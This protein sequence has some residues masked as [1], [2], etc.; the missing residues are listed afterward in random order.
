MKA[1]HLLLIAVLV[2]SGCG[3][4]SKNE[5]SHHKVPVVGDDSSEKEPQE[6]SEWGDVAA[7][8]EIFVA[9]DDDD[10]NVG[11]DFPDDYLTDQF[12]DTSDVIDTRSDTS[13]QSAT[14]AHQPQSL[15]ERDLAPPGR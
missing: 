10:P 3:D 1:R 11:Y 5:T 14:T 13:P 8:E 12:I 2:I 9:H 6:L 7:D 4:E 15:S